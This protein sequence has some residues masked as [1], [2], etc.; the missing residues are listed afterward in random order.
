MTKIKRTLQP[1]D[2]HRF[3]DEAGDLTFFGNGGQC[4]LGSPGVSKSFILGMAAYKEPLS[5]ARE[6]IESFTRQITEDRYFNT[7]PSIIK[8]INRNG[9]YLHAKDDP[10]EL[11]YQFLK[12]MASE[13][14]FT[15]QAIVA[16][17]E[18]TRFVNK[19]HRQEREFYA[20]L[21]S[22]LL[23]DKG[24]YERLVLTI[25]ERGSC[26]RGKNLEDAL[27]RTYARYQALND[28]KY[29][30][31]ICFNIQQYNKEPLLVVIDYALWTIQRIF[32]RGEDR[33]YYLIKDK[34]SSIFD[35]YDLNKGGKLNGWK[36]YYNPKRPLNQDNILQ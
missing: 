22:H 15:I 28:K 14:D 23:K 31:D 13:I 30:A 12:F 4:I 27:A 35:V 10:Q 34:I 24:N 11:R 19:H 26:T 7:M 33:H 36:N 3:I 17:K 5:D 18:V 21:L 25:A 9:F 8:R 6:K 2:Y 20:D 32:E 16:R 1:N 29:R